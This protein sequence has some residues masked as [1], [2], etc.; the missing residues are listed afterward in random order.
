M[1]LKNKLI[2][3]LIVPLLTSILLMS[4]ILVSVISVHIPKWKETISR[5]ML[6][7][8]L[9]NLN[10]RLDNLK[11]ITYN[12]IVNI[13]N[14]VLMVADYSNSINGNLLPVDKYY[15]N[16]NGIGEGNIQ[17]INNI[18]ENYSVW[19]NFYDNDI[20]QEFLNNSNIL[21]NVWR[22]IWKSNMNY[23]GLYV[24]F[25]NGLFRNYPY[26][27]LD[28]FPTYSY[29]CLI[30]NKTIIGYDPKCR[31]WYISSK[32][33]QN[34][35]I[36]SNPYVGASSGKV[37]ISASKSI[38]N[39]TNFI[40]VV[41]VDIELDYLEKI[42]L[43]S[44]ILTNGY[45]YLCDNNGNLI[46]YPNLDRTLIYNLLE[47]EFESDIDKNNFNQIYL[48]IIA[49]KNGQTT[50]KKN[51]DEW[52]ITFGNIIE[53]NYSLVMVVPK[54]DIMS[55]IDLMS[56]KINK[57]LIAVIISFVILLIII[58]IIGIFISSKI[59][60]Y[61]IKPIIEFNKTTKSI[62]E[63]DLEVELGNINITSPDIKSTLNDF[64]ILTKAIK[65]ANVDYH[66]NNLQSAYNNY[67]EI[68]KILKELGNKKGLGVV[69]NNLGNVMRQLIIKNNLDKSNIYLNDAINNVQ[70]L[71]KEKN[72]PENLRLLN[73]ILANRFMNLALL[74][75]DM[76]NFDKAKS[77][78]Q[79]SITLHRINNNQL[80][81]IKAVGN[82]G[83]LLLNMNQIDNAKEIILESYNNAIKLLNEKKTDKNQELLQYASLNMGIF[84]KTISQYDESLKYFYFAL[85]ISENININLINCCLA[86]IIQIYEHLN[87][88]TS[89]LKS[90]LI[91]EN[92]H[93]LFVLD[94]SSSMQGT[95]IQQCSFSISEILDKY[96][97][98]GDH[99]SFIK[100]SSRFDWIINN[101]I[102]PKNEPKKYKDNIKSKILTNIET[103]GS[104]AFYDALNEACSHMNQ[105][106]SKNLKNW[107][108]ALTDGED[109]RSC[110]RP[111]QLEKSIKNNSNNLIVI[112]VG[113]LSNIQIIKNLCNS[114][115][116]GFIIETE[117]GISS[118]KE[119]FDQAINIIQGQNNMEIL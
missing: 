50:F 4:V 52:F 39:N 90:K 82:L 55:S 48:N 11:N 60:T 113:N 103:N 23:K 53:T 98:I 97:Y 40:G 12:N 81:E 33:K 46:I 49:G 6:S 114:S 95:R 80:G 38:H 63:G 66:N 79:Q 25:E 89:L 34:E 31:N 17:L 88:D 54:K 76:K 94:T 86:N 119:A 19:Y 14:D 56:N 3:I 92:K 104:T 36:F 102:I 16:V 45:T 107:I 112:T 84:Y 22:P 73:I 65:F 106:K 24:G 85:E 37:L 69:W 29:T 10:F 2:L 7:E 68:E 64:K 78:F 13:K 71:Q 110:I 51:K 9:S 26:I 1:Q 87:F 59:S 118:I 77:L 47:K 74:C 111:E 67:L 115:P 42:L 108:I 28:N 62:T 101:E 30:N 32:N 93:L 21:I 105:S 27:R 100:F 58:L 70:E 61:I 15:L 109:N 99:L 117:N 41:S 5:H 96:L 72:T 43:S 8:E 91:S 35:V 18:N 116:N 44:K 75:M 57:I 83:L 20:N